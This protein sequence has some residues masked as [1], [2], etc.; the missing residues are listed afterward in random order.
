MRTAD[1]KHFLKNHLWLVA[2]YSGISVDDLAQLN[3][4]ELLATALDVH[5][6]ATYKYG[7]HLPE[8]GAYKI[9]VLAE[10]RLKADREYYRNLR[11]ERGRHALSSRKD[12]QQ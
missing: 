1:A 11:I 9:E 3:E 12:R 6:T 2:S 8:G 7:D 10:G 5:P 4:R